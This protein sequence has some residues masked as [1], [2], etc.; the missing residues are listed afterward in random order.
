M[1]ITLGPNGFT[2]DTQN[3]TVKVGNTTVVENHTLAGGSTNP[4]QALPIKRATPAWGGYPTTGHGTAQIWQNYSVSGFGR[5]N[6]TNSGFDATTGRFTAPVAGTYVLNMN[7]IN[8]GANN[9]TRYSMRYNGSVEYAKCITSRDGGSHSTT[10][11][12]SVW[13]LNVGDYVECDVFSGGSAHGGS[14][15]GFSGYYVG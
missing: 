1:S 15:N 8:N 11:V 4:N 3:L 2:T 9:N 6:S 12:S 5:F 13:Y 7:G 14:W 10:G